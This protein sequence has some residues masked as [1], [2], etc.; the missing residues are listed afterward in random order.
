[1]PLKN[2][3]SFL[4]GILLVGLLVVLGGC[5]P[6][7]GSSTGSGNAVNTPDGKPDSVQIQIDQPAQGQEKPLVTLTSSKLVYQLYMTL[8]A[9]PPMPGGLGCTAELGPHYTLTF[10]QGSQTLVTAL[11]R[12]D[13]CRPVTITGETGDRQATPTFWTQLD[14]AIY[15]GTPP[16]TPS[17]LA[18][19]HTPDPN[20]PP[21]TA[22]IRSA[23]TAQRLY[24]AILAL[25]LLLTSTPCSDAP[26]PEEYQLVFQAGNQVIPASIHKACNSISLEGAFQT[27]GGEY[28]LNDQFNHLF[29][30]IIAGATFAPARPDQLMMTAEPLLTASTQGEITDVALRQQLYQQFFSLPLI[31]PQPDC[32]SGADKEAGKGKWYFMN[33]SQWNLPILQVSA[34]EGSCLYVANGLTNQTLQGDQE[35]WHLVH[36]AADQL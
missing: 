31:Q 34:Y 11:A 6:G 22:Q 16:A 24:N 15:A 29:A 32:P 35:F 7:S 14:Q 1:M 30:Q 4:P 26:K 13:G 10:R 3:R 21:Q 23:E 28:R 5:S 36:Q 19:Q 25:P 18:I 33:F 2:V 9:L 20:Q 8:L 12:R 27:R 17:W